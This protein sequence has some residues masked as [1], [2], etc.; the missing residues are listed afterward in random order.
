MIDASATLPWCFEEEATVYTEGLLNRCA[1]GEEVMVASVWPLE[2]TNGLLSAQRRGRVTAERVEQFL[3]QL[4]W[5]RIQVEPLT[6]QQAVRDVR[7][8]AQTHQLTAY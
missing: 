3:T 7:Q 4:L 1:A 6:T 8:L 5:F 2:I